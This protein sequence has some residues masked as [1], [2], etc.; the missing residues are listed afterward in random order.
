MKKF[1]KS[2]ASKFS[3]MIAGAILLG[4]FP[5]ALA[6][7]ITYLPLQDNYI[8][9]LTQT[10]G[11]EATDL[12]ISVDEVPVYSPSTSDTFAVIEPGTSRAE[13]VLIDSYDSGASTLTVAGG[14]RGQNLYL[15]DARA[16]KRFEHPAGSSV[17]I[18]DNY[19]F[20]QTIQ[21]AVNTK[22]D[23]TG[24]NTSTTFDLDLSGSNFRIRKDGNDMKFT[25]DNQSEVSLSTLAAAAGANDKVKA[26]VA[27]TTAGYLQGKFNAGDGL[28]EAIGTPAG[29]ETLDVSVDVTDFI[30]T[31]Y[32]LT[33]NANDI[34]V[35]LGT[36]PGLEFVAGTLEAQVDPSG[37]ISKTSSGLSLSNPDYISATAGENID[38]ST[39]P[40][41]AFISR[42][43]TSSDEYP[44]QVQETEN[45]AK[46]NVWGVNFAAQTFTTGAY[47]TVITKADL[48]M[49][50][51]GAPGDNIAVDIYAVDGS[52]KPT[53]ASL[54]TKTLVASTPSTAYNQWVTFTFASPITVTPATEYALRMTVTSGT[55]A[56]YD[57]WNKGNG[58]TY[59]G[60]QAWTSADAGVSWSSQ[61]DDFSFRV[62]GYEAQ[63]AG[64]VYMS[65]NDEPFRGMVHGFVT[66]NTVSGAAATLVYKGKVS[67]L[68]G[69]TSG[70][71][72]YVGSTAGGLGTSTA[73]LKVGQA[74]S[75]TEVALDFSGGFIQKSVLS[76]PNL[77]QSTTTVEQYLAKFQC[78]FKPSKIDLQIII[79]ATSGVATNNVTKLFNGNYVSSLFGT[80]TSIVAS[81]AV[82]D[83]QSLVSGDS[84]L[85]VTDTGAGVTT[86]AGTFSLT[87][88]GLTL[89]ISSTD[90]AQTSS[91]SVQAVCYR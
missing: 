19:I 21:T 32:G 68:S 73:G 87:H 33:E 23:Q 63:T 39:T 90:V 49:I 75:T 28:D 2:I 50:K 88:S 86:T 77:S 61:S 38:G 26:S 41:A 70:A 85:T 48:L 40:K 36:D 64:R 10:L 14:G 9:E 37:G 74:I 57:G 69:L 55:G 84:S 35:N 8:Q 27:D 45:D 29:N 66:S 3:W 12:T 25:D 79:S 51:V 1:F 31:S 22:L 47:Q 81:A 91:G 72:Y 18:S 56:A 78:G 5:L 34:R 53:G 44:M 16:T 60:G 82:V 52:H 15:G 13:V 83:T 71:L 11:D 67:S 59:S 6:S 76:S 24:G 54:G 30:D 20:W 89:I 4:S 7:N 46:T 42:G 65:D 43:T 80:Q 62:W 17:V 58:N